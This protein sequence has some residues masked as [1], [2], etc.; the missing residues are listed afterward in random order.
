[1]LY[2]ALPVLGSGMM[3][4][5]WK[6][7]KLGILHITFTPIPPGY[8][9]LLVTLKFRLRT[10]VKLF[11]TLFYCAV[12]CN[13]P[14]TIQGLAKP[15]YVD[16]AFDMNLLNCKPEKSVYLYPLCS[17]ETCST[18]RQIKCIATSTQTSNQNSNDQ[19]N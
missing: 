2:L 1:L 11:E 3:R 17:I 8:G 6:Y 15:K 12:L 7:V 4:L 18:I 14:G 19:A 9:V 5:W 13:F 16:D 10:F